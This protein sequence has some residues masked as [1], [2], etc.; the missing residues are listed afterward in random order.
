V[1]R[2]VELLRQTS[3]RQR[4]SHELE[5]RAEAARL[6][7]RIKVLEQE[8]RRLSAANEAMRRDV[9]E[10]SDCCPKVKKDL[11]NLEQEL[12]KLREEITAMKPKLEL[13]APPAED[14][15]VQSA[16]RAAD[17][18]RSP[19]NRPRP[20][21]RRPAPVKCHRLPLRRNRQSIFF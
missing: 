21:Q 17:P 12:T 16:P 15:A 19:Q 9:E 3:D 14:V 1:K 7:Q 11:T 2:E 13:L 8:N 20:P 18:A 10:V 4:E 5:T 6:N